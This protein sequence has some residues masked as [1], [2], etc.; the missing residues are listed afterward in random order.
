VDQVLVVTPYNDT[1]TPLKKAQIL[2]HDEM[3]PNV[4]KL[5]INKRI[6]E[7]QR[8]Q[9]DRGGNMVMSNANRY[10]ESGEKYF[11][12]NV[13]KYLDDLKSTGIKRALSYFRTSNK[14]LN[15]HIQTYA[16]DMN[17]SCIQLDDGLKYYEGDV[18][19]CKTN[20]KLKEVTSGICENAWR[21]H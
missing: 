20:M 13:I 12:K 5:N 11:G 19:I 15:R 2:V 3:F 4:I 16:N 21:E 7:D 18:L 10:V 1:V 17:I 6:R 9:G 8:V 14:T